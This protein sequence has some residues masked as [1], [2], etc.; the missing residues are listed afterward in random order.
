RRGLPE[1]VEEAEPARLLPDPAARVRE[2]DGA[3]ARHARGE[4]PARRLDVELVPAEEDG[5]V[6]SGLRLDVVERELEGERRRARVR[7][8]RVEAA[9]V[10]QVE[11]RVGAERGLRERRC[12]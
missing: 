7:E 9:A 11:R 1:E 3:E 12:I 2:L 6:G 8:D 5:A 10:L 4:V